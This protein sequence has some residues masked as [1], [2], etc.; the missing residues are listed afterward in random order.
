[1]KQKYLYLNLCQM[2]FL[3]NMM[4]WNNHQGMKIMYRTITIWNNNKDNYC[5]F[6]ENNYDATDAIPKKKKPI[7]NRYFAFLEIKRFY[8]S[9][10]VHTLLQKSLHT[11]SS[12]WSKTFLSKYLRLF[13]GSSEC[14]STIICTQKMLCLI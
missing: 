12:I 13:G 9:F 7:T 3:Q 10:Y 2:I 8:Y 4:I 5:D 6:K 1:M 14:V 11:F